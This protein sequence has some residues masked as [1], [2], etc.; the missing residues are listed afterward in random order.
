[1]TEVESTSRQYIPLAQSC[2]SIYFTLESL[3]QVHFLYQF[4]LP[5]FLDILSTVLTDNKNLDG[6]TNY[7]TRL[8]T[9]TKDL[10]QVSYNQVSRGMLHQDRITFAIL[11][12]RIYLKLSPKYAF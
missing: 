9:I 10:F 11:L 2:S 7:T 12:A 5:F 1:M 3:H 8:A 6:I 4:S